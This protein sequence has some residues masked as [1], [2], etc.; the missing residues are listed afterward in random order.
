MLTCATQLLESRPY[1]DE[2]YLLFSD[3]AAN[4][5]QLGPNCYPVR[6]LRVWPQRHHGLGGNWLNRVPCQCRHLAAQPA[7]GAGYPVQGKLVVKALQSRLLYS[8]TW[9][10][11]V[12]AAVYYGLS[13]FSSSDELSGET[14]M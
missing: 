1:L 6:Q 13:Y 14:P 11:A 10:A 2:L 8:L 9:L 12:R 4:L 5:A 7:V 3:A